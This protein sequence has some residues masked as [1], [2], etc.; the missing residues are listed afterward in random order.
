MIYFVFLDG[1]EVGD[2]LKFSVLAD[3]ECSSA[4]RFWYALVLD[5][6]VTEY[7]RRWEIAVLEHVVVDDVFQKRGKV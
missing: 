2:R 7:H 6:I 5:F 1:E 3:V 4:V